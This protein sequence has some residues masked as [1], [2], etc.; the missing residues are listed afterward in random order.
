L[1]D[2]LAAFLFRSVPAAHDLWW[3]RTWPA[4]M[5]HR[6]IAY[7]PVQLLFLA[8]GSLFVG[9]L[10]L[11]RGQRPHGR[12]IAIVALVL[13][14]DVIYGLFMRQHVWIHTHTITHLCTSVCMMSGLLVASLWRL[15]AGQFVKIAAVGVTCAA[16]LA[17]VWNIGVKSYGNNEAYADPGYYL[18]IVKALTKDLPPDAVVECGQPMGP[19]PLVFLHRTYLWRTP[20][21]DIK[22]HGRPLYYLTAKFMPPNDAPYPEGRFDK[23]KLATAEEFEMFRLVP[24]RDVVSGSVDLR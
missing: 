5:V 1:R 20:V 12:T 6:V 3:N 15:V 2:Y 19:T 18:R 22:L 11:I 17:C 4:E 7:Y 16:G 10:M 21:N 24:R 23:E 14:C 13:G 8:C 9:G